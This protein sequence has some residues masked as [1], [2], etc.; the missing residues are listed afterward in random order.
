[1]RYGGNGRQGARRG[2][3]VLNHAS[4]KRFQTAALGR[5]QVVGQGERAQIGQK[6]LEVLDPPFQLSG[7]RTHPRRGFRSQRCGGVPQE[8]PSVGLISHAKG[9][10]ENRRVGR[11]QMV[12][13]NGRKQPVLIGGW[14]RG[15][16][17][18]Q[19]GADAAQRELVLSLSREA[20]SELQTGGDPARLVTQQ[21][22]RRLHRPVLVV[23][24]RLHDKRFIHGCDRAG[25]RGGHK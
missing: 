2:E 1:M 4:M 14:H 10:H 7:S 22:G 8:I 25:G 24:Q 19:R 3:Q 6:A 21:V 17:R 18:G 11:T 13:V 23:D 20:G 9:R 12:C 15:Q 16:R 5:S